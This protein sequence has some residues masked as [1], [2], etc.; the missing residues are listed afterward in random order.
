MSVAVLYVG[1]VVSL[2]VIDVRSFKIISSYM[3][4]NQ[5]N[6][7][8][9]QNNTVTVLCEEG[10]Q[11]K[12][13]EYLSQNTD[14]TQSTV[15]FSCKYPQHIYTINIVGYIPQAARN[16][17]ITQ[18]TSDNLAQYNTTQITPQTPEGLPGA[19]G[20]SVSN[21]HTRGNGS[22]PLTFILRD[23]NDVWNAIG[24]SLPLAGLFSGCDKVGYQEYEEFQKTVANITAAQRIANGI[25]SN[26]TGLILDYLQLVQASLEQVARY[27]ND[28][29]TAL[30]LLTNSSAYQQRQIDLFSEN[31][32]RDQLALANRVTL[33]QESMIALASQFQMYEQA[34]GSAFNSTMRQFATQVSFLSEQMNNLSTLAYD[35]QQD[36]SAKFGYVSSAMSG[37]KQGLEYTISK[38]A[39]RVPLQVLAHQK[40][41]E[42]ATSNPPFSVFITDIGT[43]PGDPYNLPAGLAT[44]TIEAAILSYVYNVSGNP[45]A[46]VTTIQYTCSGLFLAYNPPIIVG[47]QSL[48]NTFGPPS[49]ND[50]Q[51]GPNFC[52]CTG[53]IIEIGCNMPVTLTP[54]VDIAPASKTAWDQR[55]LPVLSTPVICST[56]PVT[57]PNIIPRNLIRSGDDFTLFQ[58]LLCERGLWFSEPTYNVNSAF[59]RSGPI[60][61]QYVPSAC[62][63]NVAA[64]LAPPPNTADVTTFNIFY[65]MVTLFQNAYTYSI[66]G[67]G[68]RFSQI[69]GQIPNNMT[70][71]P[72]G[73]DRTALGPVA[74]C[75]TAVIAAYNTDEFL[76]VYRIDPTETIVD[77]GVTVNGQNY[78][79]NQTLNS[80]QVTNEAQGL[81]PKAGTYLVGDSTDWSQFFWNIPPDQVVVSSDAIQREG[82]IV[83]PITADKNIFSIEAWV[84]ANGVPFN[85]AAGANSASLW[86]VPMV[87]TTI[88]GLQNCQCQ[89]NAPQFNAGPWCTFFQSWQAIFPSS[90]PAV[91]LYSALDLVQITVGVPQG[92]LIAVKGS[93]CPI[94]TSSLSRFNQIT[95]FL[96]NNLAQNNEIIVVQ[97]GS[98]AKTTPFTMS[99]KTTSAFFVDFCPLTP[100]GQKEII[101]FLYTPGTGQYFPCNTTFDGTIIPSNPTTFQGAGSL[102]MTETLRGMTTTNVA[103]AMQEISNAL[104]SLAMSNLNTMAITFA[105]VGLPIF[106]NSDIAALY[107]INYDALANITGGLSKDIVDNANNQ[108]NYTN[109]ITDLS[110]LISDALSKTHEAN[111]DARAATQ[112]VIDNIA[113][114]A[115]TLQ[116][117]ANNNR[118][119]DQVLNTTRPLIDAMLAAGFGE[120]PNALDGVTGFFDALAGAPESVG[121]EA[122]K[123]L[124]SLAGSVGDVVSGFFGTTLGGIFVPIIIIVFMVAAAAVAAFVA[125]YFCS[126]VPAQKRYEQ[127]LDQLR[128]IVD[129][130]TNPSGR[131]AL[132][133]SKA[134]G[135]SDV[136]LPPTKGYHRSYYS[137]SEDD[138]P[139]K[140]RS[141]CDCC[142]SDAKPKYTGM[143][144]TRSI[145]FD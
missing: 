79:T 45:F 134:S 19:R 58:Q 87:C 63:G 64:A 25:L 7:F 14:G 67:Y 105:L 31:V 24:C 11:N 42:W 122:G 3:Q 9:T 85:H 20:A 71:L 26:Q 131:S 77:F 88:G 70:Y 8:L 130:L 102:N 61:A 65:I 133:M 89:S 138:L 113:K 106:N 15:V 60:P 112:I 1:F 101:T 54:V 140:K 92:E 52:N 43:P 6:N 139:T 21:N 41:K 39:L 145:P 16:A 51:Q 53:Q 110:R 127:K 72:T 95:L 141:C 142:C 121:K 115:A 46:V 28:T 80:A 96:Y 86:K 22:D 40:I 47:W 35:N 74:T 2:L 68:S 75:I 107:N 5:V 126:V 91:V 137:E 37:I 83:Y 18:C 114:G 144:Q 99:P 124:V 94:L 30:D 44:F 103:L 13:F 27:Q 23:D 55:T 38:T 59:L 119:L 132:E 33:T 118:Q 111:A 69:T 109:Q 108:Y 81:L 49:C 62:T 56:T 12:D 129:G 32:G 104:L 50:T 29:T 78:R 48:F 10:D 116:Q 120:N 125:Y 17:Y 136:E 135:S 57:L 4:A 100:P 84:A 36:A 123:A 98:C 73:F 143:Q 128:N 34:T 117:I 82:T 90:N 76:D 97:T 66:S 93:A